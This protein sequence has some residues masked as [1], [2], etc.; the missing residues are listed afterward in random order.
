MFGQTFEIDLTLRFDVTHGG[1]VRQVA[2]RLA[3][4]DEN[5]DVES[6]NV[7]AD[8]L[9]ATTEGALAIIVSQGPWFDA[10]TELSQKVEGLRLSSISANDALRVNDEEEDEDR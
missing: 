3:A 10:L 2:W 7:V 5:S 8:Q 9:A 4:Y 1:A 6:D